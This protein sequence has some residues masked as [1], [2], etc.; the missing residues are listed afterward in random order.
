MNHFSEYTRKQVKDKT[1]IDV[2]KSYEAL[3]GQI[4]H[5]GHAYDRLLNALINTSLPPVHIDDKE[6]VIHRV[7]RLTEQQKNIMM[8]HGMGLDDTEIGESLNIKP[9][10]VRSHMREA[11]A[12]LAARN[13]THGAIMVWAHS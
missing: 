13:R 8:L 12:K 6:D 5:G 10:T 7:S 3:Q 4:K 9:N 1:G 2:D 11:M